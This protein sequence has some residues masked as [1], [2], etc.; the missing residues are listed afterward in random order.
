MSK[1]IAEFVQKVTSSQ[2]N[3]VLFVVAKAHNRKMQKA[4]LR[5][6]GQVKQ[7]RA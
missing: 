1:N 2:P 7:Q 4:N 3:L 6:G 5:D